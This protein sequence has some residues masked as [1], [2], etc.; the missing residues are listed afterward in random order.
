MADLLLTPSK[1]S[2]LS[3]FRLKYILE[4]SSRSANT[5]TLEMGEAKAR[6]SL[7]DCMMANTDEVRNSKA[8]RNCVLICSM[9][10]LKN[11]I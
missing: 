6:S 7:S 5:S 8:G 11:S 2:L 9:I 1:S 10:S 4:G 3:D